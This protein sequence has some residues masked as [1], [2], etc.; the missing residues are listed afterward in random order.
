MN[1]P[2][3]TA[4]AFQTRSGS[5]PTPSP[6]DW[7]DWAAVA[8]HGTVASPGAR[9]I[10]YRAVLTTTPATSQVTPSVNSVE[11]AYTVASPPS[12]GG[13]TGGGV[14]G[15]TGGGATGGTS[16]TQQSGTATVADKT[17]P[18]VT[19]V[20][21]SLKASKKGAVSFAVGCPATEQSCKITVKL[22]NGNKTV[23]SKTVNI[24][25]GKTKTVT[26]QLNKAMRQQLKHRS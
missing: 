17:E 14:A 8:N 2:P 4:V 20:A 25:G 26:L 3:G 19:V 13:G 21:K 1:V 6:G 24:K 9:F 15:G 16:T 5:T 22:K 12:S 11:I 18:K 7:S 23:A 10:Q